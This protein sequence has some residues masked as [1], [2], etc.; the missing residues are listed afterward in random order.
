MA[1]VFISYAR[2]NR[3]RAEKLARSLEGAG[4]SVW[5][6]RQLESGSE[7]SRDIEAALNESKAVIVAWSAAA[8]AS[9]WVRDEAA[10]GRDQGKLVPI[11]L[12]GSPVPIGF[13][14]FQAADLSQWTGG[15]SP[16][17]DELTQSLRRRIGGEAPAAKIAQSEETNRM[18]PALIGAAAGIAAIVVAI[19]AWQFLIPSR[20]KSAAETI[21]AP[22]GAA[23]SQN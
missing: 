2:E 10:H 8:A 5:W 19:A 17:I 13:R 9:P 1:D 15:V 22:N 4:F 3:D 23:L 20:P 21:A 7:Y 6:D 18:R 11:R 14:Q 12:D 16:E